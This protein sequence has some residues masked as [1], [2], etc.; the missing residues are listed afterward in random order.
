MTHWKKRKKGWKR[1]AMWGFLLEKLFETTS[2]YL[3]FY[4]NFDF[5]FIFI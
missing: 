1:R 2:C 3:C 4:F 5:I